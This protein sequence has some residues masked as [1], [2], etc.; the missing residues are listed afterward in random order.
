MLHEDGEHGVFGRVGL[1]VLPLVTTVDLMGPSSV[2][3]HHPNT[4]TIS[5][6]PVRFIMV[7]S[8]IGLQLSGWV[9]SPF[10]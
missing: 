10:P 4:D 2:F 3:E 5:T 9:L 7:F 8:G 1:R 6:Q